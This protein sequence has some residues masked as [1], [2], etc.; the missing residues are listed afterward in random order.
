MQSAS[1]E[2]KAEHAVERSRGQRAELLRH[3]DA[4]LAVQLFLE[5]R[6]K[7]RPA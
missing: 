1:M 2:G 6:E 5:R 7:H 4:P 3:D